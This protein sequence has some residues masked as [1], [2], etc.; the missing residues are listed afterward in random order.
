MSA[1]GWGAA[2]S[3]LSSLLGGAI[4]G[5]LIVFSFVSKPTP[6]QSEDKGTLRSFLK[7]DGDPVNVERA[8]YDFQISI[9]DAVLGIYRHDIPIS[10]L[11]KCETLK[12]D[13]LLIRKYC[14]NCG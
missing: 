14:S 6:L 4:A 11:Q 7:L 1:A 3:G 8:F 12:M 10:P 2:R 5:K 9:L 13:E